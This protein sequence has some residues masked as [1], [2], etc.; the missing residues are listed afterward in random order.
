MKKLV[1][2]LVTLLAVGIVAT[3]ASATG[4]IASDSE[5][6]C[7]VL[8]AD[9]NGVVTYD[10]FSVWYASGKTYLRCEAWV[11]NDTGSRITYNYDNT[12]FL[13][14]ISYSGFTAN[15]TNT[16][17]RNGSSQLTCVGHADPAAVNAA[18]SG[19]SGVG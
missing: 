9:G 11:T 4:P 15:W 18:A 7:G 2:G 17:G 12:G 8:D 1:L 3:T 10:S 13:C 16:I 19:T 14:F 6:A 5:F